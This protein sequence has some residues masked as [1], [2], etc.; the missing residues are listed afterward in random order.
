MFRLAAKC[1]QFEATAYRYGGEELAAI[2]IATDSRMAD[3]AES[4][5]GEV[6]KLSFESTSE[7]GVTMSLG[8]ALTPED[9]NS[10]QELLRKADAALYRA[11]HGGCNCVRGS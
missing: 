9:G 4:V 5:R 6:E 2:L 10:P 11:K 1:G 7:V 3:F 8:V